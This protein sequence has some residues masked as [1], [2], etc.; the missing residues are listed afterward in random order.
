MINEIILYSNN[1]EILKCSTKE[2]V[3]T[4]I[5]ECSEQDIWVKVNNDFLSLTDFLNEGK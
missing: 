2:Y 1:K 5:E 3:K 4:F